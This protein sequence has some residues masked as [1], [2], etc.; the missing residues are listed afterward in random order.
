MTIGSSAITTGALTRRAAMLG[1]AALTAVAAAGGV[2][3]A[4]A[5]DTLAVRLDWSTHGI[6][7]P[8]FLAVRKGWLKAADLDVSIE[9]GNGST[10]TAQ[11]IGGG[12]F[13]IGHAAL[14]PMA[15]GK[16]KGLPVISVAGF[17]RKGDTGVLVP[18]EKSWTKPADLIGKKVVYT[19]GSLEGP[20]VRPFFEKNKVPIDQVSLLNVDASAKVGTYLSGNA[21]AAISTVPFIIPIAAGKRDSSGIL[22][23]D[24]GLDLPGF[25]ILVHRDKLKAK[26]AAI[27]RFVSVISGAWT[28]ILNGHEQEGADAIRAERPQAQLSAAVLK[29]QIEAYRPF[30]RTANTANTPIGV[31]SPEDWAKTIQDLEEAETIARGTK[32]TDYFTNDYVDHDL[33]R[34]LTGA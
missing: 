29:A 19:A 7:A 4:R 3:T 1:T 25:G 5:A 27:K 23:A 30:F 6:H 33:F 14:A 11:L 2:G 34:K 31:Q 18:T 10:T 28:Y 16:A 12:Q 32:P 22:F 8:F 24:F 21:D 13:D 15:I 17:I 9:D 20:F 26:G